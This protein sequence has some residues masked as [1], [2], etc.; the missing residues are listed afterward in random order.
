VHLRRLF[1]I[2]A[3]YLV[4]L[5]GIIMI[6]LPGPGILFILIGLGILARELGWARSLLDRVKER[7]RRK[8]ETDRHGSPS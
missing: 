4:L 6:F 3:G 5:L 2:G 8:G 1:L 7:I